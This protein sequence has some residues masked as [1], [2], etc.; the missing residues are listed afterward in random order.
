MLFESDV[1]KS[2]SE[3]QL[4]KSLNN[5]P[6]NILGIK[7]QYLLGSGV[8]VNLYNS[9]SVIMAAIHTEEFPRVLTIV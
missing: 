6:F 2:H 7:S 5:A 4:N 1:V 8:C 3:S 9:F